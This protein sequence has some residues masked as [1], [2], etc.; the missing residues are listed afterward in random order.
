MS[1]TAT[2]TVRGLAAAAM[3][4][5][6]AWAPAR[7]AAAD[8]TPAWQGVWRGTVAGVPVMA[9]LQQNDGGD[10]GAYYYQRYRRIISLGTL[11]GGA[12]GAA[13]V[14]TETPLANHPEK[15]ALWHITAATPAHLAGTWTDGRKSFPIALDRVAAPDA[16]N[17]GVCGSDAFSLPRYTRP[18]MTRGNANLD[19]IPYERI[20]AMAGAQFGDNKKPE[21]ETFQL[22][23]TSPAIAAINK[24]LYTDVP[25]GA[26]NDI[27]FQCSMMELGANGYDGTS[28]SITVPLLI[29]RNWMVSRNDAFAVC[30]AAYPNIGSTYTTWNLTKGAAVDLASW[31]T[32]AAATQSGTGAN[33]TTTYTPD[34]VAL[35]QKT[36]AAGKHADPRCVDAVK[37]ADSW[38]PHLTREGIAFYPT[39]AHAIEVCAD[40]AVIPFTTLKPYL[41]AEGSHEV[42][43][44]RQD[45]T[46]KP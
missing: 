6:L 34:F 22:P 2:K 10:F 3:L 9:C 33:A 46:A 20:T 8:A 42:A 28:R 30:G 1:Q 31:F 36:Y 35:I 39:L 13:P 29:T 32:K 45:L 17:N 40:N 4:L 38:A 37:D 5:M 41:N 25:T 15:G 24:A 12:K 23:G 18:T 7:A 14:W 43:A 27:N 19:G 21:T 44:F 16:A 11:P 26:D